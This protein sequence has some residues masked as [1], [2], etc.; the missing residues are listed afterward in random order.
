MFGKVLV[1]IQAYN[2]E[3]TIGRAIDSI[4]NQ[5]YSNFVCLICNNGSTDNTGDIISKYQIKDNRIEQYTVEKN[6]PKVF[7]ENIMPIILRKYSDECEFFC[8]L[9]SDDEYMPDFMEK[10]VANMNKSCLDICMGGIQFVNAYTMELC[11]QR[12]LEEG[13]IIEGEQYDDFFP[14]YHQFMRTIW[15]KMFQMSLLKHVNY[16]KCKIVVYGG[17]TLFTQEAVKESKRIGIIKDIVHKYYMSPTSSSYTFEQKRIDADVVLFNNSIDYLFLKCGKVSQDNI[18]F[19][20]TVYLNALKDT[21]NVLIKSENTDEQKI[22]FLYQ[23]VTNHYTR[24]LCQLL[25]RDEFFIQIATYICGFN[26][27]ESE[28][29]LQ[30]VA[31]ILAILGTIPTSVAGMR[32]EEYFLL[33]LSIRKY[34]YQR[35]YLTSVDEYIE[36]IVNNYPIL[37]NIGANFA[38]NIQDV[39]CLVVAGQEEEAL[40]SII[41]IIES[42]KIMSQEDIILVELGLNLAAQLET[43]EIFVWLKKIQISLYL[44]FGQNEKAAEVLEDWDEVLPNDE[45][46]KYFRLK[47]I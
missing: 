5:T 2:A 18:V 31:E 25:E 14:I 46:F 41:S 6:N 29:T 33:L 16:N 44:Q 11:G 4:L 27:F 24:D 34:W 37:N 22:D 40:N 21:F 47:C 43:E 30:K 19:L 36:S 23:M 35:E 15:G 20:F 9:D 38:D 1:Y 28:E 12:G 3:K 45:D 17:D 26:L 8:N 42:D 32:Q 39:V 13:I 7:F 10:C